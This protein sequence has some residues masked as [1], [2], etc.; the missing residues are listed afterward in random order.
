MIYLVNVCLSKDVNAI[1]TYYEFGIKNDEG[2][3][4]CN[5]T[6]NAGT[7]YVLYEMKEIREDKVINHGYRLTLGR[8][9]NGEIKFA[10]KSSELQMIV[11]DGPKPFN[12]LLNIFTH[13]N[14]QERDIWL[15]K[16]IEELYNLMR[17]VDVEIIDYVGEFKTRKVKRY[18]DYD[19]ILRDEYTCFLPPN[20]CRQDDD[21]NRAFAYLGKKV[22]DESGTVIP[23]KVVG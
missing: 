13:F 8:I 22:V 6:Y 5:L 20:V 21:I 9:D 11:K 3:P 7:P 15:H 23:L 16:P 18:F 14:A 4:V 1:T 19:G 12:W 17:S 10:I 2:R